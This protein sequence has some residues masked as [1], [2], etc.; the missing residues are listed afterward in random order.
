MSVRPVSV[1]TKKS[2]G[3][4]VVKGRR[5]ARR[6]MFAPWVIV[7]VVAVTAFLGLIFARTSLDNSAFELNELNS[8]IAEQQAINEELSIEIARLE[9]PTN[10]ARGLE[11][12]R[13]TTPQAEPVIES[14]TGP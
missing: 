13:P 3:F 11:P 1:D 5:T 6:P 12:T 14:P 4:R 7:A 8:S 2:T 9:N 10:A